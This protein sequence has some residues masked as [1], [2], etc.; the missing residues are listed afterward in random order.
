M[1]LCAWELSR[2]CCY[3]CRKRRQSLKVC[4][5]NSKW[6]TTPT[7]R[8]VGFLKGSCWLDT[9]PSPLLHDRD[10]A[11]FSSSPS[12][13][14]IVVTFNMTTPLLVGELMSVRTLNNLLR[15]MN[16]KNVRDLREQTSFFIDTCYI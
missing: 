7:L 15:A 12:S 14:S 3:A 4:C 1:A 9:T 10:K 16:T 6:H 2:M 5:F 11:S 8:K 13:S